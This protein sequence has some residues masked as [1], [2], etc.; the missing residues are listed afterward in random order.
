MDVW[1]WVLVALFALVVVLAVFARRIGRGSADPTQLTFAPEAIAQAR[2]LVAAGNKIEAIKV[3]RAAAPGLGLG[4]AKAMV[5][6]MAAPPAPA[7]PSRQTPPVPRGR[8]D[9]PNRTS[10]PAEESG[11][12]TATVPLEVELEA[13]SLKASGDVGAAIGCVRA[14]TTLSVGDATLFVE[15]L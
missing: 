12:S 6:R 8:D 2:S 14:G 4:P 15:L 1:V 10:A 11:P 5:D 9:S 7:G 3:L 13:R